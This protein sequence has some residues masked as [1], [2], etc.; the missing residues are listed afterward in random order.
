MRKMYAMKP[1]PFR[2]EMVSVDD[3]IVPDNEEQ[4]KLLARIGLIGSKKTRPA[5]VHKAQSYST[6]SI[7]SSPSTEVMVAEPSASG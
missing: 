6:R 2:G 7:A 1:F 3:E 5:P 4:A